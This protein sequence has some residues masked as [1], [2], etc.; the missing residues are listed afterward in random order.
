MDRPLL[1]VESPTKIKTIKKYLGS[2]YNIVATVGHIKDLPAKEIGINIEKNFEP[3]Y[4]VIPGKQKVVTSLKKAAGNATDIYLAPD[5]DREGE[6][7]AWHTAE[8][9]KKKGRNFYRVLI[10]ELTKKAII[11]AIAAS[12]DL[13]KKKYEAQQ[14]RRILDRIVGYQTSPLLWRKVKGGLSAGRVQSVAVRIIC[15][16][17]RAIQAFESEEYWSITAFLESSLPPQFKAK[18]VKKNEKK[19]KIPDEKASQSILNELSDNKFIVNKVQKK[20]TKKNPLPPFITSKL[21]QEAIRKLKFSAKKTMMVAQQL[22][23]GVD[24]GTSGTEGLITYMRTDSTRISKEAAE[25]AL[26]LIR[27]KFG[28]KFALDKPRFFKNKKKVQDAHEAIRPT[29]VFNT[30]E[31][32]APYLSKDQ[33]SLYS[34]IWKR[35]IASQMQQALINR[36]TISIKA[37]P[38]LFTASGSSVKFPGFMVLYMSVDEEIENQKEKN[39]L[40]ELSEGT[41]LKVNKLEPRQHFT[42]PP[43]RFSEASLV[44]ELEENGIGRPSTYASILSTIKEKGYVDFLK[45]YF[46]PSELGFIVN[47]LLVKS[48][49]DIFEVDF[50]AKMEEDLDRIETSETDYLKILTR[51]YAP[52]KKELDAAA[53]NMLSMRGVGIPTDLSCPECKKQLHIKVGKN[54][55]YLACNGYP[56]CRHTSNYTRNEKGKIQPIEVPKDEISDIVCEKCKKPMVLKHGKFG[57]FLACTGYPACKNTKSVNA[58]QTEKTTGVKCP[59]KG[60]TGEI[61][62][63]R[64]KRGKIFYSC[65]RYPDCTFALWDKPVAEKC[66]DCSAEFLLEKSTKKQGTFLTCHNKECGYKKIL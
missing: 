3:K 51:F 33:L 38:Y 59:E 66:P 53:E 32:L 26:V 40:P 63:R 15:E 46:K 52:F 1:V 56:E 55:H 41:E 24:I 14:A 60:C 11:E 8:V 23:E 25:E 17:E 43:P 58:N 54:G 36:N 18:L 27:K 49:P 19:L 39:N 61:V 42:M 16:R 47:D 37:G 6:A 30:P 9:L 45:G 62:E 20:V 13:H 28:E 2:Q 64:S 31:K 22:Y 48:F 44:K 35:F 5:P 29:S 21:Q 4:I 10:H 12:E 57:E 34:L 50:T 65:N 7:I